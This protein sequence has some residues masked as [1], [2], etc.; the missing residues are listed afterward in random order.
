MNTDAKIFC[1]IQLAIPP[2]ASPQ[3]GYGSGDVTMTSGTAAAD[4][5]SLNGRFF[6]GKKIVAQLILT[7]SEVSSIGGL[8]QGHSN[9]PCNFKKTEPFCI[10]HNYLYLMSLSCVTGEWSDSQCF[11]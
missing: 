10:A 5:N 9:L 8:Y 1:Y 6:A 11:I 4:F 2:Y 3:I 7:T